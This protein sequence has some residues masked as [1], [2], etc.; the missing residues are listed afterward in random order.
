MKLMMMSAS[1]LTL[2]AGVTPALAAGNA[3]D[4]LQAMREMNLIVLGDMTGGADVEGKTFVGGNLSNAATFGLGRM[5][6]T[7]VTSTLPTLT[8]VGNLSGNTNINGGVSP[9]GATVGGNVGNIDLNASNATLL[10]GGSIGQTNGGNGATIEAGGSL[11]SN[12][13]P[14]GVLVEGNLG[15]GFS[16]PLVSG[17]QSQ[18]TVLVADLKA[19][20]TALAGLTPTG[21]FDGSDP[22]NATFNAAD[23]GALGYSVIDIT[24]AQYQSAANLDY[25]LHGIPTIINVSGGTSITDNANSNNGAFDND[26]LFNFEGATSI[27]F[28]RQV[29]G[30][31]LAPYATISNNSPL[32]GSVAV[33]GFNQGGEVHQFAFASA[34]PGAFGSAT[35]EPAS[36]AMMLAGFGLAGAALRRRRIAVAV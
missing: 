23:P 9:S 15:P 4:G 25:N 35:P 7:P 5:G 14:T 17:L 30:S 16:G 26:V 28:N 12:P 1:A 18:K 32:E 6:Q 24:A 20:S 33:A 22:N 8:V 2:F 29:S 21:S 19:L 10:V 36:W 11:G 34:L 31:V 13:N 27:A 3:A